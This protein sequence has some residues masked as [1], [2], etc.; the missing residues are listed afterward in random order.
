L[1]PLQYFFLF[2]AIVIGFFYL[3][4]VAIFLFAFAAIFITA[5]VMII[6]IFSAMFSGGFGVTLGFS[7]LALI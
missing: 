7:L 1:D 4:F 3:A 2:C 5:I 6:S